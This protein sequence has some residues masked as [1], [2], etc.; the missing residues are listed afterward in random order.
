LI[1]KVNTIQ[2]NHQI[3]FMSSKE[4]II[5]EVRNL[6]KI[7]RSV[8]LSGKTEM[9][10]ALNNVSFSVSLGQTVGIV[11]ESG[12]GKSTIGRCA[13]GLTELSSGEI[14]LGGE[15]INYKRKK[16]IENFR[17]KIQIVFQNP[18]RSFNPVYNI[19]TSVGESLNVRPEWSRKQRLQRIEE[20]LDA[21]KIN[22][23]L[24]NRRPDQLSGGQL[25]RVAIARAIAPEPN[26]IFLDEPTSSL[27]L[28]VRSEVLSLLSE[29]QN[30]LNITYVFVSH[31]LEVV[32]A[33]TNNIIVMYRGQIVEEGSSEVLF[34]NPSHPYT[35]ALLA[36]S[37]F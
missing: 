31:D 13:L 14:I 19:R 17:R 28:S 33:V 21:V 6:T 27:D 36:A 3:I 37:E 11:G 2:A 24:R 18:Q 26:L 9:I 32:R 4:K 22:E 16:D 25:Q 35:Q 5:F 8:G 34:N 1:I 23:E 15:Q 29:L 7:F 30:T 10:K 12:S 20:V